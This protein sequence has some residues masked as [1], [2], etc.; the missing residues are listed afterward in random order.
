[1]EHSPNFYNLFAE[2]ERNL[3]IQ[4]DR[5]RESLTPKGH[6]PGARKPDLETTEAKLMGIEEDE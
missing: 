5:I 1:M 4:L 6:A 2:L 3:A